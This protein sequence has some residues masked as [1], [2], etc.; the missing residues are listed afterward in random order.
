[1]KKAIL[2]GIL[3]IASSLQASDIVLSKQIKPTLRNKIQ[4]DL[5]VIENFK[6][7]DEVEPLTL[8]VMGLESLTAETA[9]MWL[10]ERVNYIISEKAKSIYNLFLRKVITV[11]KRNV[12][13]PNSNVI[14]YSLDN[15]TPVDDFNDQSKMVVMSNIG[16]ALYVDGKNKKEINRIKIPRGFLHTAE[17]ISVTSP[18]AGIIQIGEGLFNPSLMIN[19]ENPNALSN[20]IFRLGTFFHEARHSDGNGKSLGFM[21]RICPEGHDYEGQAA[22]DESLNGPYTVGAVMMIEMMKSC[23][24]QSSCTEAELQTLKMVIL[25]NYNR[26]LIRTHKNEKATDWDATPESL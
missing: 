20:T 1:M 8:H 6:F 24:I 25:D 14:P 23:K 5:S 17:K 13:F 19:A 10:N 15:F 18:R 7:S 21:H 11:E 16:S 9:T 3:L 4:N 12:E 26:R 2:A 22:C